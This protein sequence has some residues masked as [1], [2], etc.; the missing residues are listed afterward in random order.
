MGLVEHSWEENTLNSI[1]SNRWCLTQEKK[2]MLN[3]RKKQG[4]EEGWVFSSY[5]VW[6]QPWAADFHGCFSH[7]W[8]FRVAL[9]C[10]PDQATGAWAQSGFAGA[11]GGLSCRRGRWHVWVWVASLWGHT[12]G[13]QWGKP[14]PVEVQLYIPTVLLS[15]S[16]GGPG[17]NGDGTGCRRGCTTCDLAWHSSQSWGDRGLSTSPSPPYLLYGGTRNGKDI[18]S[19]FQE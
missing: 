3:G 15:W 4:K 6:M 7:S 2:K 16:A 5:G 17:L 11:F 1:C 14:S 8:V 12:G 19:G 18:K 10:G 9:C 13:L